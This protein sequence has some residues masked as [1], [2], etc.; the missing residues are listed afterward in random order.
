MLKALR[1][2]HQNGVAH[3]DVK[4]SNI[5]MTVD[6]VHWL[7]DFGSVRK[8]GTTTEQVTAA[9]IPEDLRQPT[10]YVVTAEHDFWLLGMTVADMVTKPG[11]KEAGTGAIDFNKKTVRETL[12]GIS[13]QVDIDDLLKLL[14]VAVQER[15]G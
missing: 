15:S 7:A 14:G 8:I 11:E 1:C 6:G 10:R 9:Y 3:M 4:P 5:L 13:A 2:L 12:I